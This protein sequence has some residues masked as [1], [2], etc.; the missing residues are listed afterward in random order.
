MMGQLVSFDHVIDTAEA[1]VVDRRPMAVS[2]SMTI[3]IDTVV[4]SDVAGVTV[5]ASDVGDI[6]GDRGATG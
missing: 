4:T 2:P 3:G 5:A 6:G 1:E